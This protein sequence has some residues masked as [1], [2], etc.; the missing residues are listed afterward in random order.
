METNSVSSN[1][2]LSGS[3]RQR[4]DSTAARRQ[5]ILL[6]AITLWDSIFPGQERRDLELIAA[7]YGRILSKLSPERLEEAC[8]KVLERSKFFPPPSEIL[9]LA[10]EAVVAGVELEAQQAWIDLVED[11]E[12]W[13]DDRDDQARPVGGKR[14]VGQRPAKS[15]CP[16]CQGTGWS[17]IEVEGRG[18][19]VRRCECTQPITQSP[20]ELPAATLYALKRVGGY[21]TLREEANTSKGAWLRRDFI[22]SYVY[23][24]KTNGLQH[25]P[26]AKTDAALLA[27]VQQQT[28]SKLLK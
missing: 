25:L 21:H 12:R 8:A 1:V 18:R 14:V 4:E 2:E 23:C 27:E 17:P 7:A 20:P 5:R 6:E 11:F 13:G 9:E 22:D 10:G 19:C 26:P 15:D 24:R 3:Q 16:E 28:G